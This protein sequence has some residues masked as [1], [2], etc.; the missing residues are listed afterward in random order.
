M[1]ESSRTAGTTPAKRQWQTEFDRAAAAVQREYCDLFKFWRGCDRKACR[2]AK[3]CSGDA[4]ACLRRGKDQVPYETR[5]RA[6]A[7]ILA[8]TP[9]G[10][11]AAERTARRFH[12]S[13]FYV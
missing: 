4:H 1:S 10:A 8:A 12:P 6:Q 9:P 5:A 13:D 2:K 7:A 3:S 11:S